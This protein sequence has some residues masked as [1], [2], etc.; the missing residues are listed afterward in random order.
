[1]KIHSTL[2]FYEVAFNMIKIN[3][4]IQMCW[5]L[6][7]LSEAEIMMVCL[8]LFIALGTTYQQMQ[9][10]L[11]KFKVQMAPASNQA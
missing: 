1:M 8:F 6:V 3:I 11:S 5:L 7:Q 10:S 9:M 4:Y 2:S